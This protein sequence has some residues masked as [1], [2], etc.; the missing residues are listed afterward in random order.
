MGIEWW[1]IFI[2]F[3]ILALGILVAGFITYANRKSSGGKG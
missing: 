2:P 1:N 3:G